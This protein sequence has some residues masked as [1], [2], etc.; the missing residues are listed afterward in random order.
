M[1]TL[2]NIL[3]GIIDNAG[4][5]ISNREEVEAA[6]T[7]NHIDDYAEYGMNATLDTEQINL[8]REVGLEWIKDV[9]EGNGEWS[10]MQYE[11]MSRLDETVEEKEE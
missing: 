6:L 1:I 10:R 11:A 4:D 9:N 3:D 2:F 8:I 7:F 5:M